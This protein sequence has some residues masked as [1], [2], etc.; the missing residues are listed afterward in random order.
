M[1]HILSDHI[2]ILRGLAMM[3]VADPAAIVLISEKSRIVPSLIQ[4]LNHEVNKVWGLNLA[5]ESTVK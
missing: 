1:R 2:A 5:G 4:M 3:T